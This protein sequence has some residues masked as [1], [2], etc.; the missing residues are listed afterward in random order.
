MD[1]AVCCDGPPVSEQ[2][3]GGV[4]ALVVHDRVRGAR[5]AETMQPRIRHDPGRIAQLDPALPQI[6]RTQRPFSLSPEIPTSSALRGCAKEIRFSTPGRTVLDKPS[7]RFPEAPAVH[8]PP[9]KIEP[10]PSLGVLE[11]II[12]ADLSSRN[13]TGDETGLLTV[14]QSVSATMPRSPP[15]LNTTKSLDQKRHVKHIVHDVLEPPFLD[16]LAFVDTADRIVG[17]Q[18]WL[19]RLFRPRLLIVHDVGDFIVVGSHTVLL[20]MV[21]PG[22]KRFDIVV[23]KH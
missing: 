16:N 21:A 20:Y 15:A 9:V 5:M 2:A 19:V 11:R 1:I 14:D 8:H 10:L 18:A 7:S 23:R 3:S 17:H 22:G 13:Q 6:I 12:R 4:Q